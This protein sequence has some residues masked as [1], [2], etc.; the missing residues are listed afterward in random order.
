MRSH[1][2]LFN[3]T[4]NEILFSQFNATEKVFNQNRIPFRSIVLKNRSPQNIG[5]LFIFFILETLLLGKLM[6]INPFN[7]PAVELLKTQT[8]KN[9]LSQ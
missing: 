9:L 1:N 6:K 8:K 2:Y 7:Q 4:I 3:K 5:E